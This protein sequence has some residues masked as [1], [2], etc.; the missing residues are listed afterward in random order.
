MF[1]S[2]EQSASCTLKWQ[3]TIV[4]PLILFPSSEQQ[5]STRRKRSED[6]EAFNTG[7]IKLS[8][9]SSELLPELVIKDTELSSRLTDQTPSGNDPHI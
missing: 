6:Q 5:C 2:M 4:P 1:P 3:E 9:L 8:S 7:T